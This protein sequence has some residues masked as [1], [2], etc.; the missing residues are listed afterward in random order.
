MQRLCLGTVQFGMN[1]G[2]N[3]AIGRQPTIEESCEMIDYALSHGI[4]TID[5]ARAYGN[6]ELVLGEYFK[7]HKPDK[8]LKIITKLRPNVIDESTKDVYGIIRSEIEDSLDRMGVDCLDGYLL[9][10]PEYVYNQDILDGMVMLKEASLTKHIGISIYDIK[11]GEA[12][13]SAGIFDYIQMPYSI[14]DQRGI[15]TGFLKK[16]RKSGLK[17]AT[18]SAFLQGL[19]LMDEEKIPEKVA[20][21]KPYLKIVQDVAGEYDVKMADLILGFVK[22]EEDI[23]Y[24]VFGVEKLSQLKEDIDSYNK[25]DIPAEC[26]AELKNRIND[27][28]TSIIFPSLWADGKKAE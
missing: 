26:I 9:H 12:A 19:L 2:I 1:Y 14:L 8:S 21:S 22:N 24:L 27:I 7:S 3:N 15:R 20:D 18:R 25:C 4:Y 17:V 11:E 13:L 10:T 23:D 5:T 28:S 6:A 16:A